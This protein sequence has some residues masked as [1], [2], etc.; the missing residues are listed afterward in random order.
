[1]QPYEISLF[2]T[3]VKGDTCYNAKSIGPRH[4]LLKNNAHPICVAH[5]EEGNGEAKGPCGA[6]QA[7]DPAPGQCPALASEP[8]WRAVWK[9]LR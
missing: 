9:L 7:S 3:I 8:P 6:R 1:M 2:E 5:L 4:S